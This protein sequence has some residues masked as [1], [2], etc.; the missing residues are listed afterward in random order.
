MSA[1]GFSAGGPAGSA[2]PWALAASSKGAS[3]HVDRQRGTAHRDRSTAH[4]LAGVSD[5]SCRPSE[6][7][8][9]ASA[10]T[11]NCIDGRLGPPCLAAP[12]VIEAS[13]IALGYLPGSNGSWIELP[14]TYPVPFG[15]VWMRWYQY[16]PDGSER[17][18]TAMCHHR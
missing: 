13:E 3:A 11:G 5:V 8:Y 10:R 16:Y 6:M 9:R 17:V 15:G 1:W 18:G 14:F 4:R 2:V 12:E 7:C